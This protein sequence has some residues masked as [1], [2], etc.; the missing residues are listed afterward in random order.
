[1]GGLPWRWSGGLQW[2]RL[3]SHHSLRTWFPMTPDAVLTL[4]FKKQRRG[5][6]LVIGTNRR[7]PPRP[8]SAILKLYF[9]VFPSVKPFQ[10]TLGTRG[11]IRSRRSPRLWAGSRAWRAEAREA[12]QVRARDPGSCH[13]ARFQMER[14]RP[15]GVAGRG[16]WRFPGS[17][18]AFRPHGSNPLN[19][20]RCLESDVTAEA[21]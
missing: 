14:L 17:A 21:S 4:C 6:R 19:T 9:V 18:P 1:M 13:G 16:S 8:P 7:D 5:S 15:C 10:P 11:A 3:P 2:R 20:Q 12:G